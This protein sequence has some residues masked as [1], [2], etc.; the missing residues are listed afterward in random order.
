[1]DNKAFLTGAVVVVIIAAGLFAWT[2]GQKQDTSDATAS[3]SSDSSLLED[4]TTTSQSPAASSSSTASSS[5]T[6]GAVKEFTITAS[7]YKF[8]P[9]TM[10]VNVGDTVKVTLKNSGGDHDFVIDEFNAA[11]KE[12]S[13]GESDTIEFVA[14]KAGTYEFYCSVS[15]HRAMGMTGTLTVK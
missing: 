11:T 1:M 2:R 7:N 12:L 4:S 9:N 10:S 8:S 14:D 3:P 6:T 15:N 13:N 5:A